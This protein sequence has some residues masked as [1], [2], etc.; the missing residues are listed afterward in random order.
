MDKIRSGMER[1]LAWYNCS[2]ID[3]GLSKGFSRDWNSDWQNPGISEDETEK[4]EQATTALKERLP[5][6][7]HA[8]IEWC[9]C[10]GNASHAA[11]WLGSA[12]PKVRMDVQCAAAWI[13]GW[14]QDHGPFC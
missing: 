8:L 2:H 14:L 5:R 11:K 9:R 10:G 3:S 4:L 12:P 7:Y 13:D 6:E 1:L